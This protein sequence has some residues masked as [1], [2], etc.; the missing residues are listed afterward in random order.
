MNAR[1]YDPVLGRFLSPDPYVQA[2]DFS[3]NFNRYSYALNN[4]LRFTDPNGEIFHIVIGAVIG[5]VVNWGIHGFK[6]DKDGLVAFGIGAAAGG[7]GAATFG[8]GLGAMGVAGAG[9]TSLGAVGAGGFMA[10]LG[11][12]ALSYMMATPVLTVGNHIAFNDPLPTPGEFLSGLAL[13]SL[14]GGIMQGIAAHTQGG[15]FFNGNP[16]SS[17]IF[18]A[19]VESIYEGT[20]TSMLASGNTDDVLMERV[21]N[22]TVTSFLETKFNIDNHGNLTDGIY[23]VSKEAMKKH[24]YGGIPGKSIFYPSLNADKAVLKAANYADKYNLWIGNKAK[25]PVINTNIG[26]LGNNGQPTNFINVYRNSNNFIHG[27]P[28]S[29]KY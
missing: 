20:K 17:Q 9:I 19:Q 18:N 3:Q 1:L 4:P 22:K 21:G 25:V 10:G 7:I 6:L 27:A 24:V 13:S 23:T 12:G 28:G 5:G 29:I 15:N 16:R 11:A 8:V 2:P 14:G 26:V